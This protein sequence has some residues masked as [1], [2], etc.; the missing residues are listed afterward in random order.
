[1]V[2]DQSLHGYK[3]TADIPFIPSSARTSL[4]I[5]TQ[6]VS[7]DNNFVGLKSHNRWAA[8]ALAE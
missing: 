4:R 2:A 1:M 5:V 3:Y 7:K 6:P 8:Q